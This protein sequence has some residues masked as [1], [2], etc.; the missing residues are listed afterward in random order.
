MA[1]STILLKD[2][3]EDGMPPVKFFD[4]SK[5]FKILKMLI[6]IDCAVNEQKV[7]IVRNPDDREDHQRD[8]NV[9]L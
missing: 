8:R 4:E 7:A 1:G 6:P 9:T 5:C 2:S 3:T